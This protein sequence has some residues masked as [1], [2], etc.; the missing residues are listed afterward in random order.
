VERGGAID[1][2]R[3]LSAAVRAFGEITG[4]GG[5]LLETVARA[6]TELLGD[7]C[8][9]ALV[10]EAGMTSN[11]AWARSPEALRVMREALGHLGPGGWPLDGPALIAE[12]VRIGTPLVIEARSVDELVARA[13]GR[14]KPWV[15]AL[16]LRRLLVVPLHV[17][18]R[19]LGAL[20]LLRWSPEGGPFDELDLE[21]VTTIGDHAAMA[22]ANAQLLALLE[23]ERRQRREAEKQAQT[24]MSLIECST[25]MISMANFDGAVLFVNAAG[26]D[27]LGIPLERDVQTMTLG[28]FHVPDGLARAAPLHETGSWHGEGVLR[29]QLTGELIPMQVSSILLR[30]AEGRSFGF[31]TVQHDLRETKRLER[32]LRQAQKMEALGRLAG[33]IAHD[34]NNLLTVIMSYGSILSKTLTKNLALRVPNDARMLAD[35][36]QIERAAQR[37]AELTRQLLAFSRRQV[38]EPK[39]LEL[40]ATVQ[41]MEPMIRRLVGEDIVLNIVV[42]TERDSVMVDAGQVEQVVMNLVVNARDAMRGGGTLTL[43][44]AR[45][46]L[47]E[48]TPELPAGRYSMLAITDTG[49]GLDEA[50]K[51]HL[52]EPFFT[53]KEP[54]KGTG[55]GLSTVMGIVQQSGGHITVE[56]ELGRGSSFRVYLPALA[57]PPPPPTTPTARTVTQLQGIQRIFVVED[58]VEVR[59]LI[60]N[61]LRSAGYDVIEAR[62][63]EHALE[64]ATTTSGE[65]HLLLTD[66]IMPKLGGPK[67]A[68]TLRERWPTTRV[69]FMSGYTDDQLGHHGYSVPTSS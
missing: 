66:V 50:T 68:A 35:V 52:F 23:A 54:G 25:D 6:A 48:S 53:T 30:D 13:E 58:E 69:L 1:C 61:V 26:R 57:G 67:V 31:A 22:I 44:T 18:G 65:I 40:G 56:T 41:Q 60:V 55:L 63:G 47:T 15:R 49:T 16:G 9:V 34:F 27:L 7:G 37:A 3:A 33:G 20:A 46:A 17:R 39:P 43:E 19:L 32:E 38:L 14:F 29:H 12:L 42:G 4:D 2:L 28:D 45:I 11:A 5:A 64:V 24:C 21:V 51:T 10:D 8:V 59:T 62:D 36:E